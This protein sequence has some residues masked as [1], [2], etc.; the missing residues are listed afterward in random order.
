MA[1][2]SAG[3][4]TSGVTPAGWSAGLVAE[5]IVRPVQHV[6]ACVGRAVVPAV[7][8]LPDGDTGM[9]E[10]VRFH[11]GETKIDPAFAGELAA[12]GG[13]YVNDAFGTAHRAHAS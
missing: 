10:N 12:L 11:P 3:T 1:R 9:L 7:K 6:E 13:L 5:L 4:T 8:A 2:S